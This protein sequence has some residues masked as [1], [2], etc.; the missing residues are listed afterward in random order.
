MHR[1]NFKTINI[2]WLITLYAILAIPSIFLGFDQHHGGL[3]HATLTTSKFA[4]LHGGGLPF[5]QYGPFWV[6]F[7]GIPYLLISPAYAFL[8]IKFLTYILY[9]IAI[10]LTYKLATKFMD[11][12]ASYA[13]V[14]CM[15]A[16]Y[17]FY[18]GNLPWPSTL[19]ML[20]MPL[21]GLLLI[22]VPQTHSCTDSNTQILPVRNTRLTLIT[23]GFLV[24][25]IF[26]TRVQ[27]GFLLFIFIVFF[28]STKSNRKSF[29]YQKYFVSGFVV[30]NA[31]I[32]LFLSSRGWLRSSLS[33]QFVFGSSYI[34]G[35]KSTYPIPKWTFLLTIIFTVLYFVLNRIKEIFIA[36]KYGWIVL[37]ATL[38]LIFLSIFFSIRGNQSVTHLTLILWKRCW[39]SLLLSASLIFSIEFVKV[40]T[41]WKDRLKDH[42]KLTLLIALSLISLAQTFPLFD[43]MHTWWGSSPGFILVILILQEFRSRMR[44]VFTFRMIRLSLIL[45]SITIAS[46]TLSQAIVHSDKS[47]FASG[48]KGVYVDSVN[49]QS[50]LQISNFLERNLD[51]S[52]SVLNLCT[53]GNVF[54]ESKY[55]SASRSIVFWSPIYANQN[56]RNQII[57]SKPNQI[58]TCTT[59]TNPKFEA[60]YLNAQMLAVKAVYTSAKL[61]AGMT[62]PK[63]GEWK[64]WRQ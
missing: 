48:L 45:L 52:G 42:S 7:Y 19:T 29:L 53:N 17:P 46:Q 43:E 54:F 38:F 1:L 30:L 61:V 15:L 12:L 62:D 44:D 32:Y 55:H 64:I 4:L 3:I 10:L 51:P 21:I 58:L 22:R 5:N 9:G 16:T 26:Q 2:F 63:G 36:N 13:V 25:T 33:D 20:T 39:I 49:L 34:T 50:Q 60:D 6:I 57:D 18:S 11:R 41:A 28:F 8:T 56:L 23:I 35:D 59:T 37:I 31:I 47:H 27:I 24:A 14:I 40:G